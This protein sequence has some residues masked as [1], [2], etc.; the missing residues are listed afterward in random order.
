VI[1]DAINE[2]PDGRALLRKIDQLVGAEHYPWLKVV[3]TSRPEA[4]RTIKHGQRLAEERYFYRPGG[5][6]YW[7]ELEEFALKLEPFEREELEGAFEKYRRVFPTCRPYADLKPT[8]RKERA[9]P[10]VLRPG[11]R[12]LQRPS[13]RLCR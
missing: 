11:G 4:W 5:D 2:N 10:L 9:T 8:I 1:F 3:V 12:D 13:P 6:D 7:V